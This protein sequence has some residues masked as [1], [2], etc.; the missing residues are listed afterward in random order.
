VCLLY[1][2]DWLNGCLRD[3]KEPDID[4]DDIECNLHE[5]AEEE[6]NG[7][8]IRNILTVG[9]ELAKFQNKSGQKTGDLAFKHLKHVIKVAGQFDTYLKGT[10][11]GMTSDQMA[12]AS[13]V[14]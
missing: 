4:F 6:M 7:R 13:V 12:K 3:I 10:K 11:D 1:L 2:W 8:Q 14:R 9:R 5:L